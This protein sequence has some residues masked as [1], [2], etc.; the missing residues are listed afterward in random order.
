MIRD[1]PINLKGDGGVWP[2]FFSQSKYYFFNSK[3]SGKQNFETSCRNN[4]FFYKNKFFSG[5][6]CFQNI[7]SAHV[8]MASRD[9]ASIELNRQREKN[10]PKNHSRPP[11]FQVKWVFPKTVHVCQW[12]C[13]TADSGDV[14][15]MKSFV[16]IYIYI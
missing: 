8:M 7:F 2:W 15:K 6:K 12:H 10:G 9:I 4:I 13:R 11:P 3:R 14:N 1:H 5:I 16:D